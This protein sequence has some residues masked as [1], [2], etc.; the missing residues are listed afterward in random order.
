M[1][2]DES[3]FTQDGFLMN[4]KV[5]KKLSKRNI[6]FTRFGR[7]IFFDANGKSYFLLT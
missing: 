2:I 1:A 3:W 5:C 7:G 4:L 6:T